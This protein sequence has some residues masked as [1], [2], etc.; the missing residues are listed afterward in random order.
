M[1]K[2]NYKLVGNWDVLIHTSDDGERAASDQL[3]LAVLCVIRDELK[4]LNAL[5]HCGN[6]IQIPQILRDI[7]RNTTKRKRKR[8]VTRKAS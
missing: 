6:C 2:L 8:K 5:L 4:K 7:K 3:Q 1:K